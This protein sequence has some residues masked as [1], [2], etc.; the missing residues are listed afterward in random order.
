MRILAVTQG[1]Y[2]DRIVD[3]IRKRGPANWQIEVYN[4]PRALP[5]I[6]D[7][8]EEF[9]PQAMPQVNLVLLLSESSKVAQLIGGIASLTG[10]K[11]IIAP[12]DD[13]SWLPPGLAKQLEKELADMGVTSAFPK[14][15]CTLT[16]DGCGYRGSYV[17]YDNETIAEFAK[18]FGRP[19]VKLT[20]STDGA[21][22]ENF[23]I[24][25]G[26]PCGSSHHAARQMTGHPADEVK[27]KAGLASHHYPCLASMQ[28]EALDDGL[29]DTLMHLSGYVMNDE[30][31]KSLDAP[32]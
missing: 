30:V 23:E 19:K 20:T 29:F 5:S 3:N 9:L 24:L 18:H 15:F 31:Q 28:Q 4:P 1:V 17:T 32:E 6:V 21:T 10:A 11:A 14:T 25:R 16:E 7:D 2:G 8:P 22:V 27:Y 12:I 13:S 26:A